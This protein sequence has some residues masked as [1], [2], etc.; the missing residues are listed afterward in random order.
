MGTLLGKV[1]RV[2]LA[3]FASV[4]PSGLIA[5]AIEPGDELCWARITSGN[6]DILLITAQGRALRFKE[7]E[8]R[9]TGRQAGGVNG[10]FLKGDDRMASMEVAEVGACLLVATQRGFG[11]RTP[12]EEYPTKGRATGGVLTIDHHSLDK[13]GLIVSARMVQEND[14]VTLITS[15]GQALRLRVSQVAKTSRSTRGVHLI[16]LGKEDNL[17]SIARIPAEDLSGIGDNGLGSGNGGKNGSAKAKAAAIT[18]A[19]DGSADSTADSAADG[20]IDI[21]LGGD[22]GFV[23]DSD[24]GNSDGL[25]E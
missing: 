7:S 11:K 16:D 23:D 20:A 9:P 4:R 10:I 22:D 25:I 12:V 19:D 15:G 8:V 3:E 1:K 17:A 13:I 14:E 24:A 5:I 2:S 21:A 6:D 18:P